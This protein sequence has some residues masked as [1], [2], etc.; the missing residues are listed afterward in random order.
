LFWPVLVLDGV[1]LVA[2]MPIGNHDLFD[3][4]ALPL[5]QS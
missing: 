4:A 1:M 5:S 2:A 3:T